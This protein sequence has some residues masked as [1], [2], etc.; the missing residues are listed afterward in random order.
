MRIAH[1]ARGG[2]IRQRQPQRIRFPRDWHIPPHPEWLI[3]IDRCQAIRLQRAGEQSSIGSDD[4][5]RGAGFPKQFPM[6]RRAWRYH[7]TSSI[8]PSGF[9]NASRAAASSQSV[10]T[11]R[12]LRPIPP[13]R[14]PSRLATSWLMVSARPRRSMTAK[15]SPFACI[16]SELKGIA[17]F[18]DRPSTYR[19][20]FSSSGSTILGARVGR[21]G[22]P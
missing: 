5:G 11:A 14:S 8:E 6:R 10:R 22:Q 9:Q 18:Q 1:G 13:F 2:R 20:E 16:F 3:H 4:D 7:R 19:T 12:W 15:S 17:R 21:C